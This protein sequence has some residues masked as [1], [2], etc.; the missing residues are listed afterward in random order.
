MRRTAW[1][2]ILEGV[3][4]SEGRHMG[5]LLGIAVFSLFV[6]SSSRVILHTER[7]TCMRRCHGARP[8]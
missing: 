7:V 2:V 4:Q 6:C 5:Y 3:C 8:F 1:M